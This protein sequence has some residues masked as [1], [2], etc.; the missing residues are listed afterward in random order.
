MVFELGDT[1]NVD[2]V[3][4]CVPPQLPVYHL[5]DELPPVAV[6][7]VLPPPQILVVPVIPVGAEAPAAVILSGDITMC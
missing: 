5:V 3:P 1:V 7:V 4:I 2:P 6:S